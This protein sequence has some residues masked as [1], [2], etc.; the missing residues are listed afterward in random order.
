MCQLTALNKFCSFCSLHDIICDI[1]RESCNKYNSLDFSHATT[2]HFAQQIEQFSS[3]FTFG[4]QGDPSEFLVFLLD[5]LASCT[6]INEA[7]AHMNS[8]IQPIQQ[9]FG[10]YITSIIECK[11]CLNRSGV[12]TW[13]SI[14]SLPI[15]SHSNLS[16]V[17][18]AYFSI[19]ELQESDLYECSNCGKRVPSKKTL[20]ITKESP[21]IFFNFK[22]FDHNVELNS[23]SKINM[24]ID[25][26]ETITL[27]DHFD[28]PT[29]QLNKENEDYSF[30]YTLNS[31]IVH[32]G[33]DVTNGHIFAYVRAPDGYWYK[34]D[35]ELVTP[36]HLDA[37]LNNKDAYILCYVK[38]SQDSIN[39][40]DDEPLS[41]PI[42]SSSI[43]IS[44][45]PTI[46]NKYFD[47]HHFIHEDEI[48]VLEEESISLNKSMDV[49]SVDDNS[50]AD[51]NSFN[52]N[53]DEYVQDSQDE[54]DFVATLPSSHQFNLR[55]VDLAKLQLIK[56]E[57]NYKKNNVF[58]KKWD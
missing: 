19:E 41:S 32:L 9:I 45:T 34:A 52:V 29:R 30:I 12:D 31:V 38:M 5:G 8:F 44:S 49:F 43:L 51:T 53:D 13:E 27:D 1:F 7:L 23:T 20:K 24:V 33:E 47:K 50:F 2:E 36:V 21:V 25:Y 57:K 48:E 54:N 46:S 39:I 14:L 55:S 11:I 10:F 56:T 16:E 26:P 15:S 37:V 40:S 28:E 6:K 17:L 35:D 42:H 18:A 22:R 3:S 58:L 4:E